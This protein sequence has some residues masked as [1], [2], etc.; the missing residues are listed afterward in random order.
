MWLHAIFVVSLPPSAL[1]D[2]S[3]SSEGDLTTSTLTAIKAVAGNLWSGHFR[4]N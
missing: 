4:S 2:L 1:T 3:I